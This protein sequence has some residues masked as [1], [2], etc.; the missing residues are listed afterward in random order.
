M[1][2]FP[3]RN[4]CFENRPPAIE[5][6]D[7]FVV[8]ETLNECLSETTDARQLEMVLR[9]LEEGSIEAVFVDSVAPSV[10]AQRILLAW[11]YSFLDDGERANRRSRTVT[12]NRSTRRRCFP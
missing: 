5:I 12:T 11:D 7:H 6:P 1:A 9:G 4:A 3:Q 8:N 2:L 10:F